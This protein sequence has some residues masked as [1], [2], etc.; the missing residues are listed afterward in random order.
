MYKSINTYLN[1]QQSSSTLAFY[2]LAFGLMM[3]F[4][5][6]RFAA[7]GWIEKLYILPKH[8]FTYFGFE[9]IPRLGNL[10]YLLFA[11]CA[12]AALFVAIGFKYKAAIITFFISFTYIEL[13]D[14]TT[15]LNHYYFISLVAFILIFLPA[16]AS[17]SVD[18]YLNKKNNYSF[19]PQWNTDVLKLIIAIVYFYAGLAK[20][21]SDWLLEAMPLKIWLPTNND[22]P[23]IKTIL[24][25]NWMHF[26]FSWSGMLYDLCIP[27]L[28]L[29]KPTRKLAFVLVV[30]FHVLTRLLFPIGVFPFVMIISSLVF[31]DAGFHTNLLNKITGFLK[32][33]TT[34]FKEATKVKNNK[35]GLYVLTLFMAFQ[36][37]FPFRY[38]LYQSELFWT[39]EGYR[40]SWRVMLMEKAAYTQFY[41]ITQNNEKI[42]INNADFLTTFQEKQMAFQP[43]FILEYAHIIAEHYKELGYKNPKVYAESYVA[44]N[45][46][47]SKQ[48]VLK[49]VNLA[50][51]K[52]SFKPKNWIAPFNDEIKGL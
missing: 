38:L 22:I 21:N 15:Y 33:N 43:D 16:N 20:I 6:L 26:A 23:F 34:Q 35:I 46:R 14:K 2:R 45:G 31:F 12:L 13:L 19:L 11:I 52:E 48:F 1:K 39:E 49:D 10:T 27:F 25:Q 3:L 44:L 24:N 37:V 50:N 8:R 51:Q 9:W 41:V 18:S 32:I 30:I 17:Y 28:L 36:L 40:F 47:L 7:L 4:S 42:H 5:L 29:Y